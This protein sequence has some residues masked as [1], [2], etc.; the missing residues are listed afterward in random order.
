MTN[1]VG[2]A[3]VRAQCPI[4][5]WWD[6]GLQPSSPYFIE[7]ILLD[8]Y[9]YIYVS[10]SIDGCCSHHIYVK[11][12]YYTDNI[13][14]HKKWEFHPKSRSGVKKTEP[15]KYARLSTPF[16]Q[17]VLLPCRSEL[18]QGSN[19]RTWKAHL[20]TFYWYIY[21]YNYLY[22]YLLIYIYIY[23]IIYIYIYWYIYIPKIPGSQTVPLSKDTNFKTPTDC[24]FVFGGPTVVPMNALYASRPS[25]LI[26]QGKPNGSIPIKHSYR[27]HRRNWYLKKHQVSLLSPTSFEGRLC[28]A[29]SR[30]VHW[31][32]R[33]GALSAMDPCL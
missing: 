14:G 25:V 32:K 22:L 5:F 10:I 6:G 23:I 29:M 7:H 11:I 31:W 26:L 21:I 33:A 4:L 3:E 2:V 12:P 19:S 8:I 13:Y 9:I 1:P 16:H 28:C 24:V 20:V 30:G 17:R 18:Q 15:P 27:H